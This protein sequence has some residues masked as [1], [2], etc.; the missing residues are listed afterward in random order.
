MDFPH[1][2]E[3]LLQEA[4]ETGGITVYCEC[5]NSAYTVQDGEGYC[6]HCNKTIPNPLIE[7]GFI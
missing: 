1:D 7:N 2:V 3:E 5:G 6:E 4:E